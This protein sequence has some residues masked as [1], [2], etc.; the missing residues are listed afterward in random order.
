MKTSKSIYTE[1]F[2]EYRLDNDQLSKLQN[3]LLKMFADL[4]KVFDKYDIKYMM[5]G[6]SLLGTVRHKGFIPWDD[7]ID[8]MMTR[9]EFG[10]FRDLFLEEL[11]EKYILVEPLSDPMYFSKMP[12]VFKKDTVYTEIPTAGIDAFHMMF[13]DIFIIE[14]IPKPGIYRKVIS[15]VYN[16]SFKG[17]SVC[18]DY[19]YPSPVIE[20]KMKTNEE[21]SKYYKYRRRLGFLFSHIGGMKFYLKVLN[22]LASKF[23]ETGW[24]G[25]PSAISYEREIF[26]DEVFT[27]ISKGN[28]CGMEVNIPKHFDA[29]L[30][31][32]Y[33]DYMKVPPLEQREVHGAYK[34]VL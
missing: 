29:Y 1:C 15:L 26:R 21:L 9:K 2:P 24:K 6:G 12:K 14:N 23:N 17:S 4:K 34:M 22:K 30:K 20:E 3:E 13:I 16:L 8:L 19:L 25:V 7:D 33:G 28:F 32:L 27:D 10:R 11:G 31:N 18:Y 5:S